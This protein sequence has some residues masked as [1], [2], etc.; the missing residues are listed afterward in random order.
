[1]DLQACNNQNTKEKKIRNQKGINSI[2]G[3]CTYS[4]AQMMKQNDSIMIKKMKR[5]KI[6]LGLMNPFV[7]TVIKLNL[8]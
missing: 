2:L 1:M 6:F 4:Y 5:S 3:N 8:G 7:S